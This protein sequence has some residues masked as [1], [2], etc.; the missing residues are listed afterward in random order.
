MYILKHRIL[1]RI[2]CFLV[3][4]PSR[5]LNTYVWYIYVLWQFV[6]NENLILVWKLLVETAIS[7]CRNFAS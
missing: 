2:R 4:V 5:Y 7:S 3:N 6:R 1:K